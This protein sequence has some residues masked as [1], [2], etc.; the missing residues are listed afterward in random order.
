MRDGWM[1]GPC[2]CGG[3]ILL[4]VGIIA[5]AVIDEC[6]RP[7]LRVVSARIVTTY[8]TS[9]SALATGCG[10]TVYELPDGSRTRRRGIWGLPGEMRR[11]EAR[12]LQ[13]SD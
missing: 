10:Y 3:L 12:M 5:V 13:E 7:P 11:I 8:T 4:V 1:L 6:R 9:G 2:L